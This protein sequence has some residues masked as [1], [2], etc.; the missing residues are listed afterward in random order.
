M[1]QNLSKNFADVVVDHQGRAPFYEKPEVDN[2]IKVKMKL[3]PSFDNSSKVSVKLS[4][5]KLSA[6]VGGKSPDLKGILKYPNNHP[7]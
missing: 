5:K 1:R 7:E 4:P 3:T 2:Q 6:A